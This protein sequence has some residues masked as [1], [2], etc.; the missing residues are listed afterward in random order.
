MTI[1]PNPGDANWRLADRWR[2]LGDA[3]RRGLAHGRQQSQWHEGDRNVVRVPAPLCL[4]LMHQTSDVVRMPRAGRS[5]MARVILM[6]WFAPKN[7]T[8]PTKFS[9]CWVL[10]AAAVLSGA[11][12]KS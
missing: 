2:G 9:V 12:R 4:E 7:D 5:P 10:S 11:F 8:C 6:V 3:P 1:Q